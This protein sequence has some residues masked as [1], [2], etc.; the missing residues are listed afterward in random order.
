MV[1]RIDSWETSSLY[2]NGH[3]VRV[4]GRAG[5]LDTEV[6]TIVVEN[7]ISVPPFSDAQVNATFIYTYIY[8][9]STSLILWDF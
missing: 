3:T 6:Q 4:L 2:P 8:V 9:I 1:V 5:E 7:S